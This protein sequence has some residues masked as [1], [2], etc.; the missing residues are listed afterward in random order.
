MAQEAIVK[1]LRAWPDS[2]VPENPVGWLVTAGRNR[3]IDLYRQQQHHRRYQSQTLQA[4][5]E[6]G[7]DV[8]VGDELSAVVH[9]KTH[10]GSIWSNLTLQ[11]VDSSRNKLAGTAGSGKGRLSVTTYNGNIHVKKKSR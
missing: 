4:V 3:A 1:A 7:V 5:G 9:C 6:G 11:N 8:E 10:N 2:G